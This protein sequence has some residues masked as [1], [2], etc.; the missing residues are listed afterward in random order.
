MMTLVS[1]SGNYTFKHYIRNSAKITCV[2]TKLII[3]DNYAL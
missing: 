3:F 1:F 2:K